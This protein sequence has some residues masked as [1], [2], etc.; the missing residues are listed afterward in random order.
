M[1]RI[2][3]DS[4]HLDHWLHVEDVIPEDIS[5]CWQVEVSAVDDVPQCDV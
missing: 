4:Q 1:E 5:V 2:L 3:Q